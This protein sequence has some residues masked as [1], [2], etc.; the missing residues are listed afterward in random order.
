MP[1]AGYPHLDDE[2]RRLTHYLIGSDPPP[3]V[4]DAYVRAHRHPGLEARAATGREKALLRMA[5]MGP[6][7]VRAADAYGAVFARGSLLRRKLVLL[8]AILESHGRSAAAI[9]T[10]TPGSRMTWMLSVGAHGAACAARVVLVALLLPPL[11]LWLRRIDNTR[12]GPF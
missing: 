1:D 5:S 2:C 8:V 7:F 10:A 4:M 3:A 9:D 6:V 11:Q 12:G